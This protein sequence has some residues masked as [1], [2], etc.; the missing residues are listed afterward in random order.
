Q[1]VEYLR[2]ATECVAR[3]GHGQALVQVRR[4][5]AR[6]PVPHLDDGREALARE[7]VAAQ[8]RDEER[9]QD[10]EVEGAARLLE[11]L[12]L[13]AERARDDDGVGSSAAPGRVG[14]CADGRALVRDG[15]VSAPRTRGRLDKPG[16]TLR[17]S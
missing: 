8:A 13:L 5:D 12:F 4:A 14:D 2:E 6:G 3:V 16:P 15:R 10:G 11:R 1:L 7:E 9:Q 17:H